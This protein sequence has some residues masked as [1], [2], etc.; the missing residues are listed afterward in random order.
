MLFS[1]SRMI[2]TED[3]EDMLRVE[4]YHENEASTLRSSFTQ[5]IWTPPERM[6]FTLKM[7]VERSG[8]K[9]VLKMKTVCQGLKSVLEMGTRFKIKGHSVNTSCV[10][11]SSLNKDNS[12]G[13]KTTLKMETASSGLKYTLKIGTVIQN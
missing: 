3:R 5:K 11:D 6:K 13:L 2:S 7:D 8:Y 4:V 10:K 1:S 9:S 12:S